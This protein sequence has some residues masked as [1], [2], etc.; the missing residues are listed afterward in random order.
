MD[1]TTNIN[2]VAPFRPIKCLSRKRQR[3]RESSYLHVLW[4]VANA[5]NKLIWFNFVGA[6]TMDS[7]EE[8]KLVFHALSFEHN[9][10]LSSG[11]WTLK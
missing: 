10:N 3:R 8:W 11:N 6:N 4:M 1:K 7:G 5:V 2:Q 9:I